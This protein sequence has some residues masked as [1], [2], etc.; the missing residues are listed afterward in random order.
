MEINGIDSP[1]SK[2]GITDKMEIS[3]VLREGKKIKGFFLICFFFLPTRKKWVL[4]WNM[5]LRGE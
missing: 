3:S 1:Y 4:L 5:E 2:R